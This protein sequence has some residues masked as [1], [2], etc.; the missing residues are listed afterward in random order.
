MSTSPE[1]LSH[2]RR[3]AEEEMAAPSLEPGATHV[4][5]IVFEELQ[6]AYADLL[7]DHRTLAAEADDLR[8]ARAAALQHVAELQAEL[9]A[10]KAPQDL[11]AELTRLREEV[12][13]LRAVVATQR[14]LLSGA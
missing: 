8:T 4:A 5:A 12:A 6:A 14:R 1:P 9:E 10:I 7:Q 13:G 2:A 11:P 3:I